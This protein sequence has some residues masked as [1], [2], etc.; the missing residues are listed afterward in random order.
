MGTKKL[1]KALNFL[2]CRCRSWKI[3]KFQSRISRATFQVWCLISRSGGFSLSKEGIFRIHY[4]LMDCDHIF[5]NSL[6]LNNSGVTADNGWSSN[7]QKMF[8]S[9]TEVFSHRQPKQHEDQQHQQKSSRTESKT[10]EHYYLMLESTDGGKIQIFDGFYKNSDR[11]AMQ[12]LPLAHC[13]EKVRGGKTKIREIRFSS[14]W[15]VFE[16]FFLLVLMQKQQ[17]YEVRRD[18]SLINRFFTVLTIPH[19]QQIYGSTDFSNY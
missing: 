10:N 15:R 9:R 7:S 16:F 12:Q 11:N 17:M 14:K 6:L 13:T 18:N 4:Y 1:Y 2:C 5:W 3:L 8:I 19:M